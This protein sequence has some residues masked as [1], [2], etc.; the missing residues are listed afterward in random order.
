[1]KP[2]KRRNLKADPSVLP[3][4]PTLW[5]ESSKRSYAIGYIQ[6]YQDI[7]YTCRGC[8]QNLV[9]TAADQKR[10]FEVD[11]VYIWY[12]PQLCEACHHK[13]QAILAMMNTY[14]AR[15]KAQKRE[16]QHDSA[17]LKEWLKLLIAYAQ[18][19]GPRNHSVIAMLHK[20]T[21]SSSQP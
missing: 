18:L 11:Q 10:A 6:S 7:A 16:V 2:K 12:R 3:A 14:E 13:K 21:T 19:G 4:D 8:N 9:F 20:L 17:F 1:M 5:S 15:W